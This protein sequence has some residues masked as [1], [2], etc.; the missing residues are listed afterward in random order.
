MKFDISFTA[1]LLM[2][3]SVVQP[4]AASESVAEII[5]KSARQN[6]LMSANQMYIKKDEHLAKIGKVFFESTKLS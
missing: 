3:I 6:G 1:A 4:T 2:M 5:R